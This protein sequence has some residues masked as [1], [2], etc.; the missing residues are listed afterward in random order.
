MK[1][2]D[3][4]LLNPKELSPEVIAVAFAKTSRSPESFRDIAA[5]LSDEKSAEFHEKWVVGYGHASVAEHAVLHLAFENVSRLAIEAIESNR[6][7]SYTEKSTRYQIFDRDAFFTPPAIAASRF[8]SLYADTIHLLFDTYFDSI[9]PVREVITRKYPRHE[10]ESEKRYEGRI[11]S[12]WID[13]CRY[14]LPTATLANVGMTANARVLEHAITKLLSHPLEEV[15]AIGVEMKQV[16]QSEVPTLVKYAARSD[17]LF[18]A[19]QRIRDLGPESRVF[20]P[21]SS[22]KSIGAAMVIDYA[23]DAVTRVAAACLYTL[24]HVDYARTLEHVRALPA[25][26]QAA[27]IQAA[28]QDRGDFDAPL[29]ELEHT[30]CTFD[31]VMDQGAYFDVK[32]HRIMTQTPQPLGIHLGYAVPQ[33]MVDAGFADRYRRAMEAA[34]AVY[35]TLAAE[36]PHEAAYVVPNAFNRRVL[37]TMNLRELFHFTQLRGGPNGHFAYR[38]IALKLYELACK[39][40][41]VF[42]PFMR[43]DKYPSADAIEGEFFAQV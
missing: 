31:C 37:L 28:L 5:E 8:A 7:A 39:V 25:A 36:Y 21:D 2:R 15:R 35:R 9:E 24:S 4:Y 34:A 30:T 41:P 22:P 23:A 13:N 42:T 3:I 14:L 6:L 17:Y 40:Y 32:R 19:A 38:R 18:D 20:P 10:G 12:K 43:C 27:I 1:T 26:E 29:R 11:R 33:A 16:A